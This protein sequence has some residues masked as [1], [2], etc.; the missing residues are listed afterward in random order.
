MKGHKKEK[1]AVKL[2]GANAKTIDPGYWVTR[3]SNTD[4]NGYMLEIGY[5]TDPAKADTDG[6]GVNDKEEVDSGSNP[7]VVDQFF[8][9]D[10]DRDGWQDETE[11]LFGSSPSDSESVPAFELKMNLIEGGQ[12]EIFFPGEKDVNYAIQFS[13]D[14]KDWFSLEKVI[15]GQGDAVRER[16]QV[17]DDVG[18]YRVTRE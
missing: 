17:S 5:P 16:F 4:A 3:P 9:G 13:S 6:D 15:I 10:K 7:L 2:T 12:L 8:I 14:M 11:I 18:F 1:D